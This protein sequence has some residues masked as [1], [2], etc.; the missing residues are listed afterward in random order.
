MDEFNA[1][2]R[3]VINSAV[4][5]SIKIDKEI[6]QNS[7]L[8]DLYRKRKKELNLSDRQIQIILGMDRKTINPILDGT[9]KQ[10][11]FINIIK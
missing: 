3:E 11:N 8:M 7:T 1:P 9:A 5:S 6:E 10:V 2:L 4:I